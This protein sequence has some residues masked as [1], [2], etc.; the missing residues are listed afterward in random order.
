MKR[1]HE[2]SLKPFPNL[3]VSRSSQDIQQENFIIIIF[4]QLTNYPFVLQGHNNYAKGFWSGP[5][6]Y[7]LPLYYTKESY[8][9]WAPPRRKADRRTFH[10]M[11][12]G[13]AA[14]VTRNDTLRWCHVAFWIEKLVRGKTRLVMKQ[15]KKKCDTKANFVCERLSRD[16]CEVEEIPD[17]AWLSKS[18]LDWNEARDCCDHLP[19]HELVSVEDFDSLK[20]IKDEASTTSSAVF[21]QHLNFWTA[22][23]NAAG[24]MA[25]LSSSY[26]HEGIIDYEPVPERNQCLEAYYEGTSGS[27]RLSHHACD[28]EK[29]FI[30]TSR[31]GWI[32]T[33]ELK[34]LHCRYNI[35]FVSRTNS[36]ALQEGIVSE[37]WQILLFPSLG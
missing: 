36:R 18:A 26:F 22:G 5:K 32:I 4:L 16:A 19:N 12:Q 10:M 20:K 28:K 21:F 33:F 24:S 13:E 34:R 6:R 8:V 30:C 15:W 29:Q 23:S 3:Q 11:Y 14:A 35:I 17:Q 1:S 27:F 25:F 31:S 7:K 2:L 9:D 37:N